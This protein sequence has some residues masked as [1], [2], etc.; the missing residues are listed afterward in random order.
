VTRVAFI[1]H[2]GA[3]ISTV[4]ES[5]DAS[6]AAIATWASSSIDRST[7]NLAPA[8]LRKEGAAFDL[9]MAFGIIL[10]TGS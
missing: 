2:G 8:E 9:P 10:S 1:H 7:V 4:R 3:R 6:Q 5:R